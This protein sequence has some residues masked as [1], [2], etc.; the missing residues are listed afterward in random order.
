M[1]CTLGE[2][3]SGKNPEE[4]QYNRFLQALADYIAAPS[5]AATDKE[6]RHILIDH[7]RRQQT[8]KHRGRWGRLDLQEVGA[9]GPR[10]RAPS[11]RN[12]QTGP[13][14]RQN[15]FSGHEPPLCS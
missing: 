14:V 13:A 2:R 12:R 1:R 11:T 8:E 6:I 3:Q 10:W 9:S 4:V 5:G 15:Y 7:T